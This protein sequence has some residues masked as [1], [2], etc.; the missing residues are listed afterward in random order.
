M[1]NCTFHLFVCVFIETPL[2]FASHLDS[3]VPIIM[4][5][6]NGGAHL[7]FR[8][9][10]GMTAFHKAVRAKNQATLKVLHNSPSTLSTSFLLYFNLLSIFSTSSTS[11]IFST[12]IG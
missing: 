2:T 10:D 8:A 1:L 7:D 5:L 4:A 6:K 3:V 11:S 9:Q 12:F